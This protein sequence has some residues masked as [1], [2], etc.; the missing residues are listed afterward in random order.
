MVQS[1]ADSDGRPA[2]ADDP[3][4]DSLPRASTASKRQRER[5]GNVGAF[6]TRTGSSD[7]VFLEGILPESDD[8]ILSGRSIEEQTRVCL[9]RLEGVLAARGLTLEDVMK[10]E[11]QLTDIDDREVVD[12][13]Y[14]DR[15]GGT[16]PPRTT[17]GVCALPGDAGVQLDV[18][19]A[20]E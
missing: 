13:V 7:L 3:G 12:D 1:R 9:E 8:G 19:A 6:G 14:R 20:D 18:T 16:Y 15:F 4:S 10:V 17:V 5:S 11:I 2:N